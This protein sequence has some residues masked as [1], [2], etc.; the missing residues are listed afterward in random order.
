MDEI[1]KVGD[2]VLPAPDQLM[3]GDEIIWSS[4]TGRT[5][6]ATML[7]DILAEKKTLNI[8]WGILTEEQYLIIK[9]NLVAGFFPVTFHDDGLELTISSYR[10]TLSKE[11]IGRCDDGI[12][13]YRSA[14]CEII[15]Q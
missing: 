8:V 9:N 5:A 6:D 10:S 13:Y 12:F 7:G 3:I 11:V 14:T 1:L 2:V 4:N 15:Q